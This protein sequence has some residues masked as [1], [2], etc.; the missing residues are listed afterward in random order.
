MF[1]LTGVMESME[2]DDAKSL[3]ER[4]GG[5][6]TVSISKKTTYLVQGRDSGVSK[7]E[8][9]TQRVHT[10]VSPRE[11]HPTE[12]DLYNHVKTNQPRC[13]GCN[14]SLGVVSRLA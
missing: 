14:G 1:V 3:I 10:D 5:K 8:K 12:N 6:V 4:Y 13:V 9:V 11:A 2:R 7:L